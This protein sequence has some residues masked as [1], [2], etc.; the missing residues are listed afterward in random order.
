MLPSQHSP[1]ARLR[2]SSCYLSTTGTSVSSLTGRLRK[3]TSRPEAWVCILNV[4]DTPRLHGQLESS[5]ANDCDTWQ[6]ARQLHKEACRY[7][8]QPLC[9]PALAHA[10]GML[11]EVTHG[12]IQRVDKSDTVRSIP[13]AASRRFDQ[14][15]C[16]DWVY[17]A[18]PYSLS[19]RRGLCTQR[20]ID[21]PHIVMRRVSAVQILSKPSGGYPS[22]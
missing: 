18:F 20:G 3:P 22:D 6:F 16:N 1:L 7:L 9:L 10:G 8:R 17:S 12:A 21:D 2:H 4:S 11:L 13:Q 19:H 14:D 5:P 15:L